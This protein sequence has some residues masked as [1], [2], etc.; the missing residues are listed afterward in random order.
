MSPMTL[1]LA[2]ICVLVDEYDRALALLEHSLSS[3]GGA[4]PFALQTDPVWDALRAN[5]R[6][7]RLLASPPAFNPAKI[8]P[9]QETN[10]G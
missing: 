5:P 8:N 6:F 1:V 7:Q 10:H 9:N 3:P 4:T 2:K